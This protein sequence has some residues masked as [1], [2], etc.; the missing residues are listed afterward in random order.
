MMSPTLC[1]RHGMQ[2]FT[3]ASKR[4]VERA[5]KRETCVP[6]E[7]QKVSLDRPKRSKLA[8]MTQADLD[9]LGLISHPV[10]G[11]VHITSLPVIAALEKTWMPVCGKCLDELLVRSGEQPSEPTLVERAFDMSVIADNA[12]LNTRLM[13][14]RQHGLAMSSWV[15]PAIAAAVDGYFVEGGSLR[16]IRVMTVMPRAENISWHDEAFLYAM[17]GPELDL[18]SGAWRVDEGDNSELLYD[19]SARMCRHCVSDWLKRQGVVD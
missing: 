1:S 11:V 5:N 12:V 7:L 4:V 9:E 15:S 16:L 8:W 2:P 18:S 17:F 13:R 6:G 19:R 10:D 3:L 14:C